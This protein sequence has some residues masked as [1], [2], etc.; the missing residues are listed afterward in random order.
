MRGMFMSA[1]GQPVRKEVR[2]LI[3]SL[4]YRTVLSIYSE[5]AM[6]KNNPRMYNETH[7]SHFPTV[8]FSV[9]LHCCTLY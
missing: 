3:S 7:I 6:W 8:L 9:V 5:V 2:H 1:V 4:N